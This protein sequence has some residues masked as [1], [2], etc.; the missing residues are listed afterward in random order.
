[1]PLL[2]IIR[3]KAINL[4]KKSELYLVSRSSNLHASSNRLWNN[5]DV[6]LNS[7]GIATMKFAKKPVN[8]IN[9]EFVTEIKTI[10][11]DLHKNKACQGLIL[12]SANPGVFSAG[13]DIL[14][15]YQPNKKRLEV[16][17][18]SFYDF[19]L[20]LYGSRLATIAAINGHS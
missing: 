9:L 18:R 11:D 2:H 20:T 19:W 4:L 8:S 17:M 16:F 10:L 6:S 1:M 13:I 15:M 3:P 14:E 12:T 7:N 5:F